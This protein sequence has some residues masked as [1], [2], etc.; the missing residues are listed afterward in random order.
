[1]VSKLTFILEQCQM[2][3]REDK[4]VYSSNIGSIQRKQCRRPCTD[5]RPVNKKRVH[6]ASR[7]RL[8]AGLYLKRIDLSSRTDSNFKRGLTVAQL[9]DSPCRVDKTPQRFI[10]LRGTLGGV[11]SAGKNFRT[12]LCLPHEVRRIA[13]TC[14]PC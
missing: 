1:M 13:S 7:D 12:N 11:R 2:R 4:P 3:S 14:R 6:G 10:V 5:L 8:V 9:N